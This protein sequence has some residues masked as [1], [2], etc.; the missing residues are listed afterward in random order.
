[1]SIYHVFDC[2]TWKQM[3]VAF[4][5]MGAEIRAG[6]MSSD[7][8]SL[9]A[10]SLQTLHKATVKLFFVLSLDSHGVF[11]TVTT[12]ARM[13]RLP[14]EADSSKDDRL[15]RR[16]GHIANAMCKQHAKLLQTH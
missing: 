2:I 14:L 12:P 7:R 4:S 8:G 13:G 6:A 11:P 16:W 9:M 3:Y 10:E 15:C 5:S 1:M